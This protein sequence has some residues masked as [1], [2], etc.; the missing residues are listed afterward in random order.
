MQ[1]QKANSKYEFLRKEAF[2][3][4]G[5]VGVIESTRSGNH[6]PLMEK[7]EQINATEMVLPIKIFNKTDYEKFHS[8]EDSMDSVARSELGTLYRMKEIKNGETAVPSKT[9]L[10]MSKYMTEFLVRKLF[11]AH[12]EIT[13]ESIKLA[14]GSERPHPLTETWLEKLNSNWKK[15]VESLDSALTGVSKK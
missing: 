5:S 14:K 1:E 15:H 9:D 10:L 3:F 11:T 7:N 12:V 4:L 6:E 2:E 13:F 8:N